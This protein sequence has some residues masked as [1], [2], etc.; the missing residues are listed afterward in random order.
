MEVLCHH[1]NNAFNGVGGTIKRLPAHASLQCPFSNQ[2][3]TPK[4][5][6][7][8]A[9]PNVNGVTSFF[10]SSVEVVSNTGF[11]KSRFATS[12]TFK[13]TQSHH[14]FIPS[15]SSLSL[16]MKKTLCETHSKKVRLT[17]DPQGW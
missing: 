2:I 10:V 12:S 15:S 8:F 11:L 6:F 9:E 1:G 4:Q 7:D 16:T 13:G 14:Q 3:L 17:A 5:L